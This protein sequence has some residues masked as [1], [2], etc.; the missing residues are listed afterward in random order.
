MTVYC[1]EIVSRDVTEHVW[2]RMSGFRNL[3]IR[4]WI[5]VRLEPSGHFTYRQ[6]NIQIIDILPTQCI[7]VFISVQSFKWLICITET[8]VCLLR[9]TD[10]ISKYNVD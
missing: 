1:L 9:G 10:W 3:T 5:I 8:G 4:L 2:A 6:F 7:Y